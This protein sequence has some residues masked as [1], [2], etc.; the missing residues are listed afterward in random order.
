MR[1]DARRSALGLI[2]LSDGL[3]LGLS[4]H[5]QV[6]SPQQ[7]ADHCLLFIEERL[8]PSTR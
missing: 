2:A 5:D 6:L 8:T 1:V 4:I 3:W 7:A